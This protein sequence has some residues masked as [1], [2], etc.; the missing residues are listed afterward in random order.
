MIKFKRFTVK[1]V[2]EGGNHIV[3]LFKNVPVEVMNSIRRIIIA[4]VP[5]LAIDKVFI[6]RNDSAIND[7]MLAHRLGL[8]PL[9][10]PKDK[11]KF[12]D[13]ESGRSEYVS[14]SLTVEAKKNFVTVYSGDIKSS[15]RD[16]YPVSKEIEIVKLAPGEGIDIEMWAVLGRGRD[17]AKWSP[18]SV[19]VVRGLPIIKI[20]K[21]C[22]DYECKKCV[23]A[24]PRNILEIKNG[25]L[26]VNNV[27]ECTVCRLCEKECPDLINVKLDEKSSL[28]YVESI[29]QLEIDDILLQAFDILLDKLDNFMMSFNE[30][31]CNGN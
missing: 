25:E 18:V 20:L 1:L 30:V 21:K 24:C 22:S 29:G 26:V 17:H 28:L 4:D 6:F 19:S 11:Y 23:S 10:T 12:S 7:D 27:Y 8:I 9:K 14:L 13:E 15:D 5:T 16:V 2:D 3:L 31:T